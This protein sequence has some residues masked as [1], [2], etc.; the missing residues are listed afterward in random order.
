MDDMI[1]KLDFDIGP[2][3]DYGK[4]YTQARQEICALPIKRKKV[5]IVCDEVYTEAAKILEDAR[6]SLKSLAYI[7]EGVAGTGL[8]DD[9]SQL[10][11][12]AKK[13]KKNEGLLNSIK[14]TS[15]KLTKALDM[16]NEIDNLDIR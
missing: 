3:G 14:D 13:K 11:N 12:M 15:E 9:Y 5:K 4:R 2:S 8:N 16:L 1:H 6:H 10:S 7:M